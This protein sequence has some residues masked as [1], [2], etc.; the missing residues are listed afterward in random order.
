[1][2]TAGTAKSYVPYF[3]YFLLIKPQDH[4]PENC[5]IQVNLEHLE[6]YNDS[7]AIRR[8]LSIPASTTFPQLHTGPQVS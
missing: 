7:R 4:P 5:L 8:K 6:Y 1:M 3:Q 2:A